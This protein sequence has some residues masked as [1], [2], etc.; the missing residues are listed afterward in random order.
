VQSVL[1][2]DAK[3]LAQT[4]PSAQAVG[5]TV[6]ALVEGAFHRSTDRGVT[7][8]ALGKLPPF[9]V[10]VRSLVSFVDADH[11]FAAN[12]RGSIYFTSNGGV[13]WEQRTSVSA[14]MRF[15]PG[16]LSAVGVVPP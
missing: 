6:F 15:V 2:S 4:P 16:S 1:P 9:E 11:G 12:E 5:D 7:W 10:A 14:G 3:T 13:S 8:T